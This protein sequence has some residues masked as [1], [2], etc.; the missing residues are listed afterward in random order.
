[1]K[2]LKKDFLDI[3][4]YERLSESNLKN[5]IMEYEKSY[6]FFEDFFS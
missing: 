3:Y 1:M 4:Y 6:K 2:R 5:I